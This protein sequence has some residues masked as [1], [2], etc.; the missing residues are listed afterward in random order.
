[1]LYKKAGPVA[2]VS[3]DVHRVAAESQSPLHP[4]T[5]GLY[6]FSPIAVSVA[7]FT[8]FWGSGLVST[9]RTS[10]SGRPSAEACGLI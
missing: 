1:M 4:R 8:P 3:A 5:W 2:Q 7:G 6:P 10:R 9:L